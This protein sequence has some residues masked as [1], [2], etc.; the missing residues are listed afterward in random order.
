MTCFVNI[1]CQ[2]NDTLLWAVSVKLEE[3]PAIMM[4][5][6][7][8]ALKDDEPLTLELDYS[9]EPLHFV[10]SSLFLWMSNALK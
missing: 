3:M 5:V 10:P 6:G 9:Y 8:W 2:S 1:T 7:L 4:A